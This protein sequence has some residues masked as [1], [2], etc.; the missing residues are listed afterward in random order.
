VL[1]SFFRIYSAAILNFTT[2]PG[3]IHHGGGHHDE[4]SLKCNI[5]RFL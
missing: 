3:K 5:S 4:F 1:V 2:A